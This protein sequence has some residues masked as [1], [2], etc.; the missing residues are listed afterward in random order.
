MRE[1]LPRNPLADKRPAPQSMSW[2]TTALGCWLGAIGVHAIIRHRRPNSNAVVTFAMLAGFGALVA[3]LLLHRT[4]GLFTLQTM[5]GLAIYLFACE[6]SVFVFT[7]V[8]GS[9]SA[10]ILMD[11][12]DPERKVIQS[13]ASVDVHQGMVDVRI[14]RMCE[15]KLLV[16]QRDTYRPSPFGKWV[17]RL[18]HLLRAF[19][20]HGKPADGPVVSS[21]P[22]TT[23]PRAANHATKLSPRF[24][25]IVTAALT[26]SLLLFPVV[27]ALA[28]EVLLVGQYE[29]SLGY[30]FFYSWR[31][32]YDRDPYVFLPQ[33]HLIDIFHQGLHVLLGTRGAGSAEI[34]HLIEVFAFISILFAHSFTVVGVLYAARPLSST[35]AKLAVGLMAVVPYYTPEVYGFGTVL[36][37]DYLVWIP[38]VTMFALGLVIR[39][40]RESSRPWNGR[41]TLILTWLTAV[42]LS[43]KVSLLVYPA[44]LG[45]M[46]LVIR[47]RPW[48]SVM[49]GGV[50]LMAGIAGWILLIFVNHHGRLDFVARYF[51]DQKRFLSSVG[52]NTLYLD[53]LMQTLEHGIWPLIVAAALPAFL[54]M[55]CVACFR[56]RRAFG[57]LLGLAVG[58][59]ATQFIL[60]SRDNPVTWHESAFFSIFA[61]SS[62]LV[63]WGDFRPAWLQR[64]VLTAV[65][66][67]GC[68]QIRIGALHSG[69]IYMSHLSS[70][71]AAQTQVGDALRESEDRIAFLI[72]HNSFRPQTIDSAIWKGGANILD[73]GFFGVSPLMRST[74][75]H[76]GYFSGDAEGYAANPPDLSSFRTI[77]FTIRLG[78]DPVEPEVQQ[79][80]M[81][82]YYSVSLDHLRLKESISSGAQLVLVWDNPT[83]R[84]PE[85]NAAAPIPKGG[86]TGPGTLSLTWAPPHPSGSL[87]IAMATNNGPFVTI[88]IVSSDRGAY[89]IGDVSPLSIYRFKLRVNSHTGWSPWSPELVIDALPPQNPPG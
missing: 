28:N 30:R 67:T 54:L 7:F 6:L 76:R 20:A 45:F 19:F 40:F 77:V 73:G 78:I 34:E 46:L 74:Y 70:I 2:L 24:G 50:S 4:Y 85:T 37:A 53:W 25:L 18:Y 47:Q 26:A 29:E 36:Q 49:L 55:G 65:V 72:P 68:M 81:A 86:W 64:V 59:A 33:G 41:D 23:A 42:T 87:D 27:A 13:A 69:V 16:R 58:A 71:T 51:S 35:L 57:L 52:S 84:D 5:A 11:H 63:G 39:C 14:A 75:P 12:L 79:A 66:L 89:Q 83:A 10:W 61:I 60:F 22:T 88:G 44:S 8:I 62:L 38:A 43:L 21:T 82:R 17:L 3:G 32:L 56:Q 1:D 9:V 15:S 31:Q 80:W 48:R